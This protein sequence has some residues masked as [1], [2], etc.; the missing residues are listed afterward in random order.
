[1][2]IK[3][4]PVT[5]LSGFLGSGKTTLL[6]HILHNREGL[7]VALIVNDM[8]DI[9]IDANMITSGDAQLSRTQETM[10]E[11]SNGCICCTLR[12]DLLEEVTALAKQNKF[13]YLLIESSG[14][15]EPLPVAETFTFEDEDGNSL[16]DFA[17]LDT[18]V[19]VVNAAQFL[20]DLDSIDSLKERGQELGE[21]D[22]R[23]I[24]QL[25]VDQIEFANVIIINK[26]DLVSQEQQE[27]ITAKIRSLNADAN[28]LLAERGNVPLESVL[29]TG[30]F[31]FEKASNAPMWL[32]EARGEHVPETEEYGIQSF[33][34][35]ARKPFHPKRLHQ[36]MTSDLSNVIRAKG[37]FWIASQPFLALTFAKAGKQKEIDVQGMWAC[38]KLQFLD[39]DSDEFAAL[40]EEL[41]GSEEWDAAFG[42]K[43]SFLVFIGQNLD[44]DT[45]MQQLEDALLTE[46]ELKDPSSWK[47][48]S[49]PFPEWQ[50][51][52]VLQVQAQ[53]EGQDE[54]DA[55][56]DDAH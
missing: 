32:K 13:D 51:D 15:S 47:D 20:D 6:E 25:L 21:D 27:Q 29:N 34:F 12:E 41:H 23:T 11:M 18:M 36:F 52:V 44:K 38:E 5:V 19:T 50:K 53:I 30:L 37:T 28:I 2:D 31:D 8:S 42:D 26:I 9:N 1:M 22:E 10:V 54:P 7:R 14:I 4:L 45:I 33:S 48:F 40:Q 39:E 46:E 17:T 55:D 24:A 43:G 56:T 49:D 16:S 35:T 3:K